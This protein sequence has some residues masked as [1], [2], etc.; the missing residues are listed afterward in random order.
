MRH[1]LMIF[2]LMASYNLFG[3]E[4]DYQYFALT[5]TVGTNWDTTLT[6]SQQPYFKDHSAHL[7]KLMENG[8]IAIGARYGD[9][10]LIILKVKDESEARGLVEEDVSVQNK[11]F[12]ASILPFNVFYFGCLEKE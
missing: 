10:G 7:K 1:I 8:K 9:K 5:Y 4:S 11:T 12:E 3:Q 6:A 2:L